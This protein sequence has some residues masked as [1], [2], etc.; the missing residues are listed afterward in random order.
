MTHLT[1]RGFLRALG[2]SAAGAALAGCTSAARRAGGAG[3]DRPMNVVIIFTDD[4]GYQDVGCFGSPLIRTPNLDRM[5]AEGARFTDF[6]VAASVCTPSRSALMTG[7]YPQRIHMNVQPRLAGGQLRPGGVVLFPNSPGGLHP[8][9]VTL[10]EILKSRG[11]A[12]ACV[13]KWHL[14]HLPQFLP[15]RQGF[16][17][18]FGIPYSNDMRIKKDGKAGPPLMRGEKVVEHPANQAT[19]T[20]RY[21]EEACRFIRASKDRPF[22]L[23]LPHTMPHLP[24]AASET[25][26]GKSKRGFYGDVI[27]EIDWSVGQVLATLK[28]CG[29]D[30]E[31]LVIFTSDNGPWIRFGARGGCAK[32]LRDGKGT[33]YEG[34]MRE[35]CIMRW[36]GRIPAGHVCREVATT[37]D[38]L[39]TLARLAGARQPQDRVIDGRDIWPL[40]S[41][42][43]GATS[44]HEAFYYHPKCDTVP[45][46]VR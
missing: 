5:A 17:S 21:T 37:M 18:Y 8:N 16:D 45:M 24:L 39:P 43:P 6:Y 9:E 1:R 19:L 4:Q 3:T 15:T 10:A 2:A 41:G 44:P 32:P 42:Q 33:I 25:F 7:C 22:F 36:P 11:Y 12:T 28:D 29:V 20:R 27:E 23:Y 30:Q 31:T 46:A 13:G 35:P 26:R 34:G 40:M 38:L 14:G